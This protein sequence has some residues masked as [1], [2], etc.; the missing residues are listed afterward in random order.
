MTEQESNEDLP[1][2]V[3]A[4]FKYK[5]ETG[6]GIEDYVKLHQDFDSM[7]EPYFAI[8]LS[9]SFRGRLLDAEDVEVHNE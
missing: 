7:D 8:K 6:R 1:E 5:K 9:N 2:D 3:Q 4:Y